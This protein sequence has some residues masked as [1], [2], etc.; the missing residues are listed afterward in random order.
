[1]PFLACGINHIS[2]PLPEREKIALSF[3]ETQKILQNMVQVGAANEAVILSTCNRVE[4]YSE[5]QDRELLIHWL[6]MQQQSTTALTPY[7]Y[8]YDDT[9]AISHVLRV[10]SGLDSMVLG[11]S[12]ILGQMKDAY[13]LACE[14][15]SVGKRLQRLF[16]KVFSITKQVRTDTSIGM[17]AVSFGYAA[18][19][20]AKRIFSDLSKKNVLLI[21]AGETI[22]LTAMHLVNQG[23]K[24]IVVANRSI[25]KA[26]QL[27]RSFYGH[28]I[29]LRDVPLYLKETDIVITATASQLPI[30]GKGSIETAIKARKHR[31][32]LMI[33]LAV[34]RDVEQEVSELEDVFLYNIDD[35]Q[36]IIDENRHLRLQAAKQAEAIIEMQA[37]HLLREL[38]TLDVAKTITDFRH[39][40][41]HLASQ[42]IQK[43]KARIKEG[44]DAE[45][46]LEQFAHNILNKVMHNPSEQLRQAAYDGRMDIITLA[47][48]LLGI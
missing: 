7:W 25:A 18:V 15:G 8:I 26:E 33:D 35:L 24:R 22:E 16:Q 41:Q 12:Q 31:P 19:D 44:K 13:A 36:K 3:S 43:A 14:A 32:I 5:T 48:Q 34:P 11:E 17:N 45:L 23:I 20:L 28:W 47:R 37:A 27:A 38:Q 6:Q 40:L 1:M 2:T 10:A 39:K 30:L 4:V 29:G 9:R 46:V 42:E 21:G